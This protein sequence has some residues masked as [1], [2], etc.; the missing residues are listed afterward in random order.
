LA[1]GVFFES[2]SF[3]VLKNSHPDFRNS[4]KRTHACQ[5][6]PNGPVS[7]KYRIS[8]LTKLGAGQGKLLKLEDLGQA[9]FILC[10]FQTENLKWDNN[11][12]S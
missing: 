2:R 8:L 1:A 5:S 9:A 7:E 6:E 12:R 4:E 11:L 10:R 3:L